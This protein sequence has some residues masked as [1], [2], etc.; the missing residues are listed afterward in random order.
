[1]TPPAQM[2]RACALED[3]FFYSSWEAKTDSGKV[4]CQ[5]KRFLLKG[6]GK[7]T[8]GKHRS[9]RHQSFVA[10]CMEVLG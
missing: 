6:T 7:S 1:M 2:C 3:F 9:Q 10:E 8:V 5:C 4:L